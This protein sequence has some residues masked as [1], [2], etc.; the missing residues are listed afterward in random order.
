M[1]VIDGQVLFDGN[2][3]CLQEKAAK[4]L[5]GAC[6]PDSLPITDVG[7]VNAPGLRCWLDGPVLARA[8]RGGF[9]EIVRLGAPGQCTLGGTSTRT[10]EN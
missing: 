7:A 6:G 5:N 2:R 4:T 8:R 10:P 1:V 9:S 3:A